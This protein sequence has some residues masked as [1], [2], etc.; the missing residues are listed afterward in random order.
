MGKFLSPL[1]LPPLIDL[2]KNGGNDIGNIQIITGIHK[3]SPL[4]EVSGTD[5]K[6]RPIFGSIS[7]INGEKISELSFGLPFFKFKR[8]HQPKLCFINPTGFSFDLHW[9]GL[10]TTADVDG[11]SGPVEFGVDT[12]I[13]T[14]LLL[15]FPPIT[16]NSTLLWVHGHPMFLASELVY[17][18]LYGLLQIVD[19]VSQEITEAFDYPN[20]HIMLVYQD[21]DFTDTGVLTSKNLYTDEQRSCFGLINGISCV[22]WYTNKEAKYTTRLYHT[23]TKNLVKIDILNGTD[24][25]RFLHVGVCDKENNIKSFYLIQ[26]DT[27][28]QNPILLD[29]V[30]IGPANRVSL[31]LDQEN[32]PEGEAYIFFYNFELTE[33]FNV[34]ALFPNTVDS[35]L[36]A[37]IP[38]GDNPTPNPT[39]IPDPRGINPQSD[40]SLLDY[41]QVPLIPQTT[42]PLQWGNQILPQK[43]GHQFTIKKFLK[44]KLVKPDN[45]RCQNQ[46][47]I[48]KTI[49]QIV[50]GPENYHKYKKLLTRNNFEYGG[51]I[52]YLSLLNKNYFY[53]LPNFD[54]PPI[55]QFILFADNQENNTTEYID[56]ANRIMVDLWD[57]T[58][59][60]LS[61]ALTQYNPSLNNY[62]PDTLPT[63]LFKIYPTD[64]AYINY[65]MLANDTLTIEFFSSAPKYGDESTPLASTTVIF[66]PTD[67]PLNINQWKSL[68]TTYFTQTM[69]TIDNKLISLGDIL[70]YDWSFYP[71][72]QTYLTKKSVYIKSVMILTTNNSDYYI[73]L[74]GSWALLQFFGKPMSAMAM[75]SMCPCGPNYKCDPCTCNPSKSGSCQCG[76]NCKCDP[77]T[78]NPSK[79]K[80][81]SCPCGPNCKCDPCTCN[82]SKC[83]PKSC[84][85]GPN[86]KCDP[87]TC[88]P[89]KSKSCPCGPNCKCDP[90]KCG[91]MSMMDFPN[92][93]NM[94]I[95]LV[96]PQYAT[97]DPQNPITTFDNIAELIIGA[98]SNISGINRWISE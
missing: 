24:S 45:Y 83:K 66:P 77:C 96:Y 35:P 21:A 12:K 25:F 13:G 20:N 82:P 40:P 60:D 64:S 28:L 58:Q 18:G 22:S 93:Y 68:V 92:N 3:F 17:S 61:Y 74:R 88:N 42:C 39:P 75:T 50:F 10:N 9:H 48:V 86:C 11:A 78:S 8:G 15:N 94:M 26:T 79:C 87:C 43:V 76:P 55:R 41:P 69:V 72:H 19:D 57:S 80:P 2:T 65:S 46:E 44:I 71:Y 6:N 29:I 30:S 70:N 63:C 67:K 89:P 1:V 4:G 54:H 98:K 97:D 49:R 33:V 73:K 23:V 53:N 16:N 62:Q 81:K 95:Q 7:Y 47:K 51:Q 36:Q 90:C 5:Y 27:G 52:N 31:L 56:G 37:T 32:F 34:E 91:M 14:Q 84:P 85:C 59:L 38:I